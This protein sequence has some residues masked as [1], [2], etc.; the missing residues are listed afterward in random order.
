MKLRSFFTLLIALVLALLLLSASGFYWLTTQTPL[1]LLQGGSTA[2]PTAAMFVPKQA[3]IMVS[4]LENPDRLEALRQVFVRPE[5]RGRSHQEFNQIK[6]SLLTNTGLDYNRDIQPWLGN[7]MTLAITSTDLDRDRNNG[8]Q[9]GLLLALAT[10]NPNRSQEFLQLFWQKQVTAGEALVVESYKGVKLTYRRAA[11]E[12]RFPAPL[13]RTLKAFP[14]DLPSTFATAIIN[15]GTSSF[16]LFANHPKV[17]RNAINN[18]QASNLNLDHAA[19][20][21]KALQ[22]LTLGRIGFVYANLPLLTNWINTQQSNKF[23]DRTLTSPAALAIALGINQQGLLAQTALVTPDGE[24]LPSSPP[25]LGLVKALEH[26]PTVSPFAVASTDLNGLWNQIASG[27]SENPIFSPF[28]NQTLANIQRN[29]A[30]D[31]PQDIFS[32]VR[33]EYAL[34]LFPRLDRLQPDWIFIAEKST[35]SQQAIERLDAIAVN[36]GYSIASFSLEEQQ[37]SAW[38]R[39]TTAEI[40]S[41]KN[42]E[43][44]AEARGVHATVGN[45]EIFTTSVEAMD[46]AIKAVQTGTLAANS[47]FQTSIAPLPKPN[48]GYLYLD[49]SS[50]RKIWERQIPLLRLIELSGK[51]FFDHLRSLTLTSIGS[52]AGV[53]RATVLFRLS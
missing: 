23:R 16:V 21:Q 14:S 35:D 41:K 2:T 18:V 29:W 26:I 30:I 44:Q 49:W 39:L 42:T 34:G 51:P 37:I 22:P 12:N 20:Y 1:N 31:L 47:E 32:W 13:T 50:S 5:E 15:G 10:S 53:R 24:P 52:Q 9:M 7:E 43:I 27:L 40:S 11:I 19:A 33:G 8:E 28:I 25:Q 46:E 3:L 48:Y 17:L 38:T 6:R 45:Y 4:L 36:Q